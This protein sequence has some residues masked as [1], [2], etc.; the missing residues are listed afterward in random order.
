MLSMAGMAITTF[1]WTVGPL[2][3]AS[4]V[5]YYM[6][7]W[8][9][10]LPDVIKFV[11][12]SVSPLEYTK[13]ALTRFSIQDWSQHP[14]F[15]IF[16]FHMGAHWPCLWST[17]HGIPRKSD[18]CRINDLEG[19]SKILWFVHGC[20]R[21]YWHRMWTFGNTSRNGENPYDNKQQG[22]LIQKY[23]VDSRCYVP[24]S[25]RLLHEPISV[26]RMEWYTGEI[27]SSTTVIA[28]MALM[29]PQPGRLVQS[30]PESCQ[31][32]MAGEASGGSVQRLQSLPCASN[33]Y[34]CPRH[35]G[36]NDLLLLSNVRR[37][38]TTRS[39]RMNRYWSMPTVSIPDDPMTMR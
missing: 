2:S 13:P 6:I 11:C 37:P 12:A 28:R 22:G 15:R 18:E 3:I 34:S 30:S 19:T 4:Q 8:D 21:G 16:K 25:A 35:D 9:R 26:D 17:T 29:S 7:E 20:L 10:S 14:G 1:S 39:Q 33:F 38:P 27:S 24:A 32:S 5:P 36:A 23:V 31:T